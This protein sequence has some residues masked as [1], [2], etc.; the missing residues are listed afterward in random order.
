MEE[1]ILNGINATTGESLLPA[2]SAEQVSRLARGEA[3][4]GDHLTELKDWNELIREDHMDVRF[5]IDS[6]KLD[7]AGWGVIFA[8]GCDPGIREALVPLLDLRRAQAAPVHEHYYRELVYRPGESKPRF[9]ARHGVGAGPADPEKLPY[10]LLLVGSPEEISFPFQY[11]LDL[12]YAVGRVYFETTE[13]YAHYAETVV[14]AESGRIAR[15]RRASFFGVSNPDDGATRRS[16]R[17]LVEPLAEWMAGQDGGWTV[18]RVLGE[19]ATKPALAALLGG[20][21]PPA[22]LFSAS[23]GVGFDPDDARQLSHQGALLCQDWPGPKTWKRPVPPD[24]YLAADDISQSASPAGLIAFH[25]ACYGAGT[26]QL[27]S[28][29][30]RDPKRRQIAPYSF[31]AR[32]PQR[33]LAHPRGGALAVVAHV[34]RA[35]SYSFDW[36]RAGE[37]LQVFESTLGRLMEGY[38]I[39][40]AM[41]YFNQRYAELSSD[42]SWE[43]QEVGYGGRPDFIGLSGMWTANNDARSYV[44][45][46]DPAVRLAVSEVHGGSLTE[47][48][49]SRSSI[50]PRSRQ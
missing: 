17:H 26:P 15:P 21:P 8:H 13:E 24:H 50:E 49:G 19:A 7:E 23:H 1:L 10:Y 32:L 44:V 16:L 46:G 22:L 47:E 48:L 38:P 42:L 4:E 9:L 45:L 39:G 11:Q 27:D 31:L 28:F 5:G 20:A 29:A 6:W 41:E 18:E 36:P 34:D 30:H 40:A 43:L 12:Q 2:L 35:W 3:W 25:F 37:Q 33:L 14:A